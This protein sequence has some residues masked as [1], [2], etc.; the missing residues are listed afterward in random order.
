MRATVPF[1]GALFA[2]AAAVS[3][4]QAQLPYYSTS[5][6]FKQPLGVAPDLCGPGSYCTNC[7]G[8][9]YGPNYNV[10]PPFQP[11][12]GYLPPMGAGCPPKGPQFATH[13]YARGPRDFFMFTEAQED[14]VTR[15]RVPVIVP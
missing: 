13:P 11:F 9:T 1:L 10:V 5:P 15:Q 6:V 12:Q 4:A 8:M 7:R 2:A 14:L 3:A